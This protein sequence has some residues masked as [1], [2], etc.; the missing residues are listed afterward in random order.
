MVLDTRF[1]SRFIMTV[2]YKMRQI[3]LQNV[4]AILLQKAT[5][6]IK[7]D[8]FITKYDSCYKVR[9]LLQITTI[10]I[11]CIILHIFRLD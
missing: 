3:L 2:H 6:I 11:S 7:C 8:D 10:D 4:T 9:R 5:V 1:H